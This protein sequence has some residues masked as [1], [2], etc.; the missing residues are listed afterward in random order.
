LEQ[1]Y[2]GFV[3]DGR[4]PG[5]GVADALKSAT[6]VLLSIPPDGDGD[7]A[8]K[9]HATD[10]ARSPSLQWIGYF[11]TVGVY[12]DTA[13]GWVDEASPTA[14]QSER[15]KR[16]LMAE[17]QWLDFGQR[18]GKC[19]MIFRL[20]GIYG[21]GR[22]ALEDIRNGTARRI[23]KKGQVFNRV[24]VADI[25]TTIDAAMRQPQPGGI[26]NVTD[27]EPAPPQDV[28][29]YAAQLLGAPV[30]PDI[31][32]ETAELS[33]MARSFYGECKRAANARIKQDLGVT[34]AY[35]TYRDGLQQLLHTLG[36]K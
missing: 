28:V 16:R 24:H 21:P 20:P 27:D 25:A 34:L 29:A 9:H 13:G 8:M 14:P 19:V 4:S 36:Q 10:L 31:D 7:L 17:R 15:G 1:G 12:A 11:S 23:V 3:F 35:P 33:P 18:S 32:F 26:Y 30:P 5:E 22:N 6:H 2:G